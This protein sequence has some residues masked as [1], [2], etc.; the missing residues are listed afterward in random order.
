MSFL[1]ARP[2]TLLTLVLGLSRLFCE[3]HGQDKPLA[4]FSDG[5]RW[6]AVGDSITESGHYVA[7]VEYFYRCRS[8]G[9][10]LSSWNCGVG[11][12]NSHGALRRF[13]TEV[14]VTKPT[15][16]SLMLGMND[17]NRG[18]FTAT[19]S[20]EFLQN[21]NQKRL[22]NFAVNL[23]ALI[24]SAAKQNLRTIILAPTCFDHA[25]FLTTPDLPGVDGALAQFR[26]K[27]AAIAR[28]RGLAFVDTHAGLTQLNQELQSLAPDKSLINP[29]RVH[30]ND[31]GQLAIAAV[32]S[33]DLKIGTIRQSVQIN[34]VKKEAVTESAD[35]KQL[36]YADRRL[37]FDLRLSALPVV[38]PNLSAPRAFLVKLRE[39]IAQ[40]MI[41]IKDL[42]PGNYS[43]LAEGKKCGVFASEEL[44]KGIDLAE[45]P[46]F[47][48]AAAS[49][50]LS[51]LI[52][53]KMH[54]QWEYRQIAW[55]EFIASENQPKPMSVVETV[56]ALRRIQESRPYMKAAIDRRLAN[57]EPFKARESDILKNI[58]TLEQSL[59][60][61]TLP[62]EVHCSIVPVAP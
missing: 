18:A 27:A 55:C 51:D 20:R 25:T 30:P 58:E 14:D 19:A 2:L 43:F 47:P 49:Q 60:K 46:L 36:T 6:S 61:V 13:S 44:E 8:G 59:D 33:R 53:R 54:Q 52:I 35:V 26:D 31:L 50:R 48:P 40:D 3:C 4:T 21:D 62:L 56:A 11:G 42:P 29:D 41:F 28:E 9:K 7:W 38:F 45:L 57:Y 32:I 15:L 22:D 24:D 12:D 16:V 39:C 17:V 1:R 10:K 23:N 34:A 37:D 5:D